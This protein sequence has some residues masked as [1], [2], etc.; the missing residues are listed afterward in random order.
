M[1]N[2]KVESV[3]K[4]VIRRDDVLGK[5]VGVEEIEKLDAIRVVRIINVDI[6][7]TCDHQGLRRQDDRLEIISELI[8]ECGD[9]DAVSG[10]VRRTVNNQQFDFIG[11]GPQVRE[12][13]V[14][15]ELKGCFFASGNFDE[16]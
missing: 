5:A 8:K 11:T 7:V 14:F 9:C 1:C 10:G 16:R 13:C 2:D 15:G 12:N 6:R 3:A 4:T